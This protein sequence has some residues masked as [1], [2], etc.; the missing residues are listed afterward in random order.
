MQCEVERSVEVPNIISPHTICLLC[1]CAIISWGLPVFAHEQVSL[2][3]VEYFYQGAK[4]WT[5]R[6]DLSKNQITFTIFTLLLRTIM[7]ITSSII[8]NFNDFL[9]NHSP[10]LLV[11]ACPGRIEKW[12][13][14]KCLLFLLCRYLFYSGY[15]V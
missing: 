7:K 6:I 11:C 1:M 10:G 4:T 3:R 13:F 14:C 8:S 15:W 12:S 2:F 5:L 9:K